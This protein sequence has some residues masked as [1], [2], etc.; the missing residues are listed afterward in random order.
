MRLGRCWQQVDFC[1]LI[2]CQG[3]LDDLLDT[4]IKFFGEPS[5]TSSSIQVF[6]RVS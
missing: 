4:R 5:E 2:D 6:Y 1:E 3:G